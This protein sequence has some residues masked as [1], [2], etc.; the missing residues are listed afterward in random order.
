M[1]MESNKTQ[2]RADPGF[3]LGGGVPLRNDFTDRW[4]KQILKAKYEER[5]IPGRSAHTLHPPSRFAP[6]TPGTDGLT[7]VFYRYQFLERC[8]QIH[9]RQFSLCSTT[10]VIFYLSTQGVISLIPKKNKNAEYLTN[11]RPV[12]LLY[13]DYKIA[14]KTIALR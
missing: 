9:G 13:V 6:E 4:G 11:C 12:S 1:M 2:G 5:F 3:F 8:Q 14:T 10:R 7:S